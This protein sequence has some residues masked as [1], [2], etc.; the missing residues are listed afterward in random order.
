MEKNKKTTH[1]KNSLG[2]FQGGGC[3]AISFIGA[4]EEA[5][6]RGVYFSELAGTSAGSIIASLVAAG[7]TPEYL[8]KLVKDV[9]FSTFN[10]TV[11]PAYEKKYGS[12]WGKLKL[13]TPKGKIPHKAFTFLQHLGL[14]SSKEIE[15][16]LND[17]LNE[18]LGKNKEI[19]KF[20]DLN[21]PL[22]VI[23]TDLKNKSHFIWSVKNTPDESVAYAVRCSSSIPFYFQPV[24]MH[25]VDGGLLSNL[26]TFSLQDNDSNFEKILC[27]TLS[28]RPKEIKNTLDYIY[29]I[30]SSV[31]DGATTIQGQLQH[32]VY[33]IKI[34]G[35]PISTTSFEVLS[36]ELIDQT[37]DIGRKSSA[38]FFDNEIINIT[39]QR[40]TIKHSKDYIINSVVLENPALHHS[41]TLSLDDTKFVYSLFPTI[42]DWI[43]NRVS[44]TFITKE[45]NY[46]N[47][48]EKNKHEKYR[49]FLLKKLG[50]TL[51]E[52]NDV[53]LNC[54]IFRSKNG[55]GNKSIIYNTDQ[56]KIK[57]I[58]YGTIYG[59]ETDDQIHDA[60]YSSLSLNETDRMK[61]TGTDCDVLFTIEKSPIEEL[62]SALKNVSQYVGE[63]IK[64]T[65]MDVPIKE[66]KFLTKYVKSY[67]YNQI[68]KFFKILDEFKIPLFN[69]C[70]IKFSDGVSFL[71][72]PPILEKYNSEYRLIE[73]NSRLTYCIRDLGL[74]S[75]NAIIVE[76]VID[77]LPSTGDY[78]SDSVIVTSQDKTG[79]T[80]YHD[81]NYNNYRKI[82]ES[83]RPPEKYI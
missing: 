36:H 26:P 80:R 51:I 65:Q 29:S 7:A 76:N 55:D 8:K 32:N 20:K 78:S 68:E 63:K 18:L 56:D 27:F 21:I 82:E 6:L 58:G 59:H 13:L 34:E 23:A 69:P 79:D 41:I 10:A 74:D 64:I 42:L 19:I 1:F 77:A 35:L 2:V 16:W 9:N 22:H 38:V 14:Y 11:D 71:I 43:K 33:N 12:S 61:K 66:V 40:K 50:V 15:V 83:V 31:V 67:K 47:N 53:P 57:K 5:K 73:G 62:Y 54:F 46:E 39:R 70:A 28:E 37:I 60:I 49:R 52:R 25:F 24:D 81:F 72:T 30:M 48:S 44:V 4:Y 75:V 3:K 17:K 45:I